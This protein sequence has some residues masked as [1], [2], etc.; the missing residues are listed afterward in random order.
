MGRMG[1]DAGSTMMHAE[2]SSMGAAGRRAGN[3]GEAEELGA[4]PGEE[5]L[6]AVFKD[7]KEAANE[8]LS[9]IC[10]RPL[11]SFSTHC[12]YDVNLDRTHI[13]PFQLNWSLEWILRL[14]PLLHL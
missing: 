10:A 5:A 2:S 9:R 7:F 13:L 6:K 3:L 14:I 4:A 8:K 1:S 11:V 12:L